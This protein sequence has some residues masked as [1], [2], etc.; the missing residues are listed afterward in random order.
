M[1]P[2]VMSNVDIGDEVFESLSHGNWNTTRALRDCLAGKHRHFVF[3]VAEV[4]HAAHD[5]E[6]DPA[7]VDAMVA[8]PARLKKAPGLIFV[9]RDQMLWLIDGIHRIHAL[10]RLGQRQAVG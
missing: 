1:K 6:F 3:N 4:A 7:K 10:H 9:V 5:T 8:D 2:L